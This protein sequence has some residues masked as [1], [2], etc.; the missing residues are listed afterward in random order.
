MYRSVL[1]KAEVF[2]N[3][4]YVGILGAGD[5]SRRTAMIF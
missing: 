2:R 4:P 3:V 5:A 1:L